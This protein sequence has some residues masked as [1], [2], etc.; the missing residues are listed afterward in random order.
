MNERCWSS[1]VPQ[2]AVNRA[3]FVLPLVFSAAAFVL[4]SAS[5]AR[6]V[7]PQPDEGASAHIWQLLM[8]AQFPAIIAFLATADWRTRSPLALFGVQLAA[9]AAAC[10]P[11]WLAG[12]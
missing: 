1:S 3:S 9:F 7:A 2:T 8:L 12:Y 6:G 11:V 4:V 10:I 5:I